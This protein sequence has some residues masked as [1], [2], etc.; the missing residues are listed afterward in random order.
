MNVPFVR[1]FEVA[2]AYRFEEFDVFDLYGHDNFFTTKANFDNGGTP[3]ISV[4]YQPIADLTLR[5]SY[6]QSFLSPA[7]FQLFD[8]VTQNFPQVTDALVSGTLQ[9]PD[10]VFQG[11]N[12][13]LKPEETDS[14]T[15]GLVYT[16]KWLSG[17]TL[18]VDFYQLFTRNV[19]LPAAD[20]AQ[21]LLTANANSGGTAFVDPDGPGGGQVA[22]NGVVGGPGIGVTRD[23]TGA[24]R[25]I[26]S[27]TANAGKRLVNGM[28][29][30]A[31]Y[32]LPT[33]N[34]GTFTFSLG[35]NYFFTWKAEPIE[36]VGSH[37]FLGDYNNGTLPLAPGA[38]P[39]HKG[40]LR[41][42]CSGMASTSSRRATTSARSTMT[43]PSCS[44]PTSSAARI[45]IRNTT[46]IVV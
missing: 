6:G 38:L 39:Y 37:S 16:P 25:A 7:G 33:Q 5:F 24:V 28:D 23:E 29:I 26:D 22:V 2:I 43:R 15:A 1:S 34:W 40:F 17:F 4:R 3:R 44:P 41:G 46:S 11:G 27:L 45:R 31:V 19:I 21:L 13:V 8:P 10:G 9:P 12:A 14:Y 42:E 20:F 30:T 18:T 32:Q 35:Y 36:G